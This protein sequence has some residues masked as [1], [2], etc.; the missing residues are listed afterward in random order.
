MDCDTTG[1]EPDF[2]LVKFKKLAGGGYFRIINQSVPAALRAL[3][4]SGAETR[5]IV[6]YCAGT[7]SLDGAPHINSD[8]LATL[9][10]TPDALDA[11]EGRAQ[12]RLRRHLRVQPLDARRG[13]LQGDPRTE[14]RPARRPVALAAR[15]PG[16]HPGAD[17]RGERRHHR[18]HDHRGLTAPARGA[19]RRLRLRQSLRPLRHALHC[20]Y[21]AR[22]RD[23]GRSAVPVGRDQQ[24]H[25]HAR[26]R[27]RRRRPRGLRRRRDDDAEGA[28]ALPRR[29][30]ALTAARIHVA[31]RRGPRRGGPRRGGGRR[32][33]GPVGRATL[34]PQRQGP[35]RR[36]TRRR[37]RGSRARPVGAAYR[38]RP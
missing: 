38:G 1:I 35:R 26:R 14:R 30:Q 10:F 27:H 5:E 25:Q 34:A 18:P 9:G 17:R 22:A 21:G 20:A 32:R 36:R 2:A 33:S 28:R 16:L 7:N 13:V 6:A 23:G 29:I 12:V 4:Y 15:S 24:D 3:G 31:R 37:P 11:V 8:S 19:L